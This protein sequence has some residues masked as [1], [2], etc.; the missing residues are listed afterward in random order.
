M[1]RKNVIIVAVAGAII[2][3][4]VLLLSPQTKSYDKDASLIF[5]AESGFYDDDFYLEIKSIGGK[6]YYTLDGTQPDKN[7]IRYTE[8]LHITDA[9]ENENIHSMRTDI[10]PSFRRD[11][12]N[13][14][15][16]EATR[17]RHIYSV[18]DFNVDKCTIVKAVIWYGGDNYSPVVTKSY[19]VGYNDKSGYE[20]MNVVSIIT[21]PVNLFDYDDGI[22][23]T[24][25]VFDEY[26]DT[27]L[28]AS[29]EDSMWIS[30]PG[31]YSKESQQEKEA[32][33]QFFDEN[34]NL[35]LSQKC[36]IRVSGNESRTFNPKSLTLTARREYDRNRLF[37][38]DLF[39]EGYYP[40]KV[41][42]FNGGN[43]DLELKI[44]DYLVYNLCDDLGMNH[45][46]FIPYVMFLDGEY[47][48]IYW[49]NERY[50]TDYLEYYYG[51]DPD[52]VVIV[53]NGM[54]E[55]P[56]AGAP[57]TEEAQYTDVYGDF[58]L[59][60]DM[61]SFV[62]GNDMSDADNYR[63]AQRLIDIDNCAMYYAIMVYTG[64]CGDW[65][66]NDDNRIMWRTRRSG[67]SGYN[68]GRWRF[69]LYDFNSNGMMTL[70]GISAI[71]YVRMFDPVFDSLMNNDDFKGR[72]FEN[73]FR[74]G[75]TTFAYDRVVN[76]I[77]DYKKITSGPIKKNWDR[78]YGVGAID[79]DVY[80]RSIESIENFFYGRNEYIQDMITQYQNDKGYEE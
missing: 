44:R 3:I 61:R 63:R 56:V 34:G 17:Y 71:D 2:L 38:N 74:L 47:W 7:S 29:E 11:V 9:S 49:L 13:E 10:S 16:I 45:K 33:C 42:L 64:R 51:V 26:V 75:E 79:E 25:R 30:W 73:L 21:D 66:A 27:V 40:D 55:M 5:S 39:H 1:K 54:L 68:D 12:I 72:L 69:L 76:V 57:D 37:R 50:D 52:G 32:V 8:P 4:A 20:G 15:A 48:G 28:S 46:S 80:N 6:V 67:G 65:P 18:P 14:Y 22:Y 41:V 77:E 23:V 78:F 60:E 58:S 62:S 36:G 24:G 31:N 59:Y 43:D 35:V 53:K 19:F 70:D